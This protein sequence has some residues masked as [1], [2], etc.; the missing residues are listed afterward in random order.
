VQVGLRQARPPDF[1]HIPD[2]PS[3]LRLRRANQSVPPLFFRWYAGSGLVIHSRARRHFT[4]RCNKAWRMVSSLMRRVVRPCA[5]HTSAAK[6]NVQV[7][8]GWPSAVRTD[9]TAA[10]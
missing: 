6:F 1:I 7:E 2:H 9:G 10:G 8:R 4:P 3:G 5:K